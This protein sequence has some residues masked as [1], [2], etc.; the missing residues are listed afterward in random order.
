MPAQEK[1]QKAKS[2]KQ[3]MPAN[4]VKPDL[5]MSSRSSLDDFLATRF[6][7]WAA[8]SLARINISRL[9]RQKFVRMEAVH[10]TRLAHPVALQKNSN[11][12]LA[13]PLKAS[14]Q[15]PNSNKLLRMS[16]AI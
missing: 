14:S 5:R 11:H 8:F 10:L 6:F 9:P 1:E 4:R 13:A 7:S 2:K 3:I 12:M 16:L 15:H